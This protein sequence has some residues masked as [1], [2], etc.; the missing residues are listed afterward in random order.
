MSLLSTIST[1][2]DTTFS[3]FNEY[4][5]H[6]NHSTPSECVNA[7]YKVD[8]QSHKKNAKDKR[9]HTL[10]HFFQK[11]ISK[12]E[13]V[14]NPQRKAFAEQAYKKLNS[15]PV[16]P[17][18]ATQLQAANRHYQSVIGLQQEPAALLAALAPSAPPAPA[19]AAGQSKEERIVAAERHLDAHPTDPHA[20]YALACLYMEADQYIP[21]LSLLTVAKKQL[22]TAP[23]TTL[24]VSELSKRITKCSEKVGTQAEA[25]SKVAK[26]IHFDGYITKVTKNK[27]S[28][29]LQ[30][31]LKKQTTLLPVEAALIRLFTSAQEYYLVL[32]AYLRGD[33]AKVNKWMQNEKVK[34]NF[35]LSFLRETTPIIKHCL[36]KMPSLQSIY[37]ENSASRTVYRGMAVTAQH[38]AKLQKEMKFVNSGFASASRSIGTAL[39]FATSGYGNKEPVLFITEGRTGVPIHELSEFHGEKEVLFA[40]STTFKISEIKKIDKNAPLAHA[41]SGFNGLFS[42]H[43]WVVNMKEQIGCT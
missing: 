13:V 26:K 5:T 16:A 14:S 25:I 17:G 39:S 22:T 18:I 38:I 40:P 43:L 2:Q 11:L 24:A 32:N 34:K 35:T 10:F 15:H 1:Q 23:S 7:M 9:G 6:L 30:G 4:A 41:I 8:Q 31:K 28:K 42:K 21:A 29:G 19:P 33:T 12:N 3:E 36:A 37:P 27:I 20:R